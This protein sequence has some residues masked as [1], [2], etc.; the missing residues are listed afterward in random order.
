MLG[1]MVN[2]GSA[3]QLQPSSASE[4]HRENS[5]QIK[6]DVCHPKYHYQYSHHG[7]IVTIVINKLLLLIVTF[8][9]VTVLHLPIIFATYVVTP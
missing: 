6:S 5:P 7:Y 8:A 2:P 9:C 4:H 3:E 1:E